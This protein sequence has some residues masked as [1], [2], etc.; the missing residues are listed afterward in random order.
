MLRA[1]SSREEIKKA[2]CSEMKLKV[3][4]AKDLLSEVERL[5]VPDR[6]QL[7]IARPFAKHVLFNIKD[8]VKCWERY[9]R[10]EDEEGFLD[11]FIVLEGL[12]EPIAKR[13]NDLLNGGEV[14]YEQQQQ[15][16][17]QQ[18]TA[19]HSTEVVSVSASVPEPVAEFN[20]ICSVIL[21]INQSD[22]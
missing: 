15:Q 16:P 5:G 6:S 21:S 3:D 9:K 17:Q 11:T 8:I 13:L 4:E 1:I 2:L 19:V 20:P 14:S 10:K 22:L 7:H 12:R 18:H